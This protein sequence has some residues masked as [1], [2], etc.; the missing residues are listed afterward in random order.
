M[1]SINAKI[2]FSSLTHNK[3][4]VITRIISL[5]LGLT[6]GVFLLSYVNYRYN[7]DNFLPDNDRL[8]K[9]FTNV[10]KE[11][12]GVDQ[13][14]HAPL[15][16]SLMRDCAEVETGTRIYGSMTFAWKDEDDKEHQL[17]TYS[18]DTLFFN[19]LDFGLIVGDPGK[20]G[21]FGNIFILKS[22]TII[23]YTIKGRFMSR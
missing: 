14:T 23:Q 15:A 6:L 4:R 18:V 17:T 21:D 7:Y 10:A 8:Y 13:L 5:A 11:G 20:L 9:V 19:V 1:K 22:A 3:G 12:G 2:A 16:H